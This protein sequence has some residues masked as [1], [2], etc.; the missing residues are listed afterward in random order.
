M[1]TI[2]LML[3]VFFGYIL[4]YRFYGRALARR[5]FNI[6]EMTIAPSEEFNDG[7]DFVPTDKWVIF[8]HHYTS[9]AGTGPIV[10][11]AIGIIWGWVPAMLWVFFGSIAIGA[12]HDFGALAISMRNKGQSISECA[13]QIVGR[14][15]RHLFFIMVFLTLLVVI[16]VFAVVMANIFEAYPSS[17]FPMWIQIPI[18]IFVGRML[19]AKRMNI[20]LITMFGVVAMYTGI[21]FGES[22]A[23]TMPSFLSIPSSGVWTILLLVYC[24]FASTLPVHT[25]LQPRDY[26]NAWQLFVALALLGFGVLASGLFADLKIV[27]PAFDLKPE[28]APPMF[29]FLFITIACGAISGFHS[30]VASGTTAKQVK[31]EKDMLFIGYGS[32]LLEGVLAVL[33]II[34]VSAGIGM[35]YKTGDGRILSGFPAWKEHFVSWNSASGMTNN[36][37]AVIQGSSN[38][39]KILRVPESVGITVMGVFIASFAGT[40]LDTATRVQRYV[41]A[42]LFAGTRLKFFS[43]RYTATIIAVLTAGA[44]AFSTG[45]SGAGAMKLWP[46]FGAINQLLAGLALLTMT[47]YLKKRG[48]LKFLVTGIPCLFM[49]IVTIWALILNQSTVWSQGKMFLAGINIVALFLALWMIL[50]SVLVFIKSNVKK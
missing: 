41:V 42:E 43:G 23:F 37:K 49:L 17:V 22:L 16:A 13:E 47:V 46:L 11:P 2:L 34:A 26:L 35:A 44:L 8:G 33:V 20:V 24:F 4:A 27:A 10:G 38:M 45:S 50:E 36:L 39:M 1:A 29:P 40:T 15:V 3:I 21:Y 14:R 7:V 31:T 48:G 12:V 18:A 9:I 19:R 32:M 28:G 6:S 25:L 5:I 30:L